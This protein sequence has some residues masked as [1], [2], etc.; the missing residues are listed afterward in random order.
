MDKTIIILTLGAIPAEMAVEVA[1][2]DGGNQTSERW[3][4]APQM[5]RLHKDAIT[6]PVKSNQ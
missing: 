6:C 5:N 1:R 3:E 2:S 4:P